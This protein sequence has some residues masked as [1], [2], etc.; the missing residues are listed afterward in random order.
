MNATVKNI[1]KNITFDVNQIRAALKATL[2]EKV[3]NNHPILFHSS[4]ETG[5]ISASVLELEDESDAISG[6]VTEENESI[7][8]DVNQIREILK[9]SLAGKV[10][11]RNPLFFSF[12]P[13][14]GIFRASTMNYN[15]S[16]ESEDSADNSDDPITYIF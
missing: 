11:R 15:E 2:P 8:L 6:S 7:S 3:T 14:T 1:N 13:E 10:T 12:T 4:P 16:N 9:T 5:D